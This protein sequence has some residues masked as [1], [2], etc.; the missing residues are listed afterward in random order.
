MSL[1]SDA[2]MGA[3]CQD[4]IAVITIKP[5]MYVQTLSGLLSDNLSIALST[6]KFRLKSNYGFPLTALS[7]EH[8]KAHRL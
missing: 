1:D 3:A 2:I 5:I 4:K 7:E 8:K 6:L